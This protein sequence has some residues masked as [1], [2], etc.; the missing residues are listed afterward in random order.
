VFRER[1]D[2]QSYLE[3]RHA[4]HGVLLTAVIVAAF[5][6][7][8]YQATLLLLPPAYLWMALRAG[9]RPEDRILNTLLLL[10]GSLSFVIMAAVM[11][12]IFHVGVVY[13]YLFLSAAYGLISAYAVVLFFLAITIMIRLFRAFVL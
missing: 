3:L 6:K 1:D 5:M 13:W 12:T 7:N 11:S 8:S 10:G 9:R 2:E 4:F